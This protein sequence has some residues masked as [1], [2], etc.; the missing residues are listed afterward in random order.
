MSTWIPFSDYDNWKTTPPRYWEDEQLERCR[1]DNCQ[2]EAEYGMFCEEHNWQYE[3]E[4]D[5]PDPEW[6][7]LE[8]IE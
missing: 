3:Y 5:M 4:K 2:R 8:V 1:W 6:E 7:M